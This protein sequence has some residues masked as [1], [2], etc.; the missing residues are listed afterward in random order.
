MKYSVE[1][2]AYTTREEVRSN[3]HK[4]FVFGDNLQRRGLGGQAREMR[5]E[6]NAIGIPTK[7]RP[8]RTPDS[9]FTDEEF[10]DNRAAI[11]RAFLEIVER[12]L[13][14]VGPSILVIP[15][16]GLGTGR[17]ELEQRAPRTFAYLEKKLREL[18]DPS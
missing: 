12:L 18:V 3:P 4:L 2:S 13:A 16:A 6:P 11:D 9:Y 15:S 7:K 8:A 17:A 1:H 5:G 10:D 14:S